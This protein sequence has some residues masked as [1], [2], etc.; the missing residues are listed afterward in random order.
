M[1]RN[2]IGIDFSEEIGHESFVFCRD[3][4][5]FPLELTL[6]IVQSIEDSLSASEQ[7]QQVQR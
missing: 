2:D 5:L 3:N 1:V 4:R 6:V 7:T